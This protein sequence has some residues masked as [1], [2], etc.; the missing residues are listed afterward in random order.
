M[1]FLS[2]NRDHAFRFY[3]GLHLRNRFLFNVDAYFIAEIQT[4]GSVILVAVGSLK[5]G[6]VS[7]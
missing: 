6:T 4:K 1:L 2:V 5:P 3:H 7:R